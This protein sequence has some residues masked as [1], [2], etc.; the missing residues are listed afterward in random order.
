MMVK[1]IGVLLVLISCGSV[2]FKMAANH[3]KEERCLH[4]LILV[5]EY[6]ISELNY[7]LTPLPQLCRQASQLFNDSFG[8][9]FGRL[10]DELEFQRYS[11]PA[12]CMSCVLE[13]TK[14]LPTITRSQMEQLGNSIGRF[15]IDGQVKGLESVRKECERH[16]LLL[17]DNKENRMRGYQTLGLCAGA[18][19][20]ILFI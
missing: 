16:L 11:D 8:N 20:A 1:L 5:L 19:L 14:S 17:R 13:N 9:I 4:N 12:Q 15:D 10:S 6:M 7:R 3:K 18:A 2:G